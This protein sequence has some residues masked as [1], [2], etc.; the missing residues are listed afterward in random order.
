MAPALF[1]SDESGA[2]ES[3]DLWDR[4]WKGGRMGRYAIPSKLLKFA[5][6]AF[7]QRTAPQNYFF[8]RFFLVLRPKI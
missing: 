3:T 2:V 6:P 5:K 8:L 4:A 7:L 1:C